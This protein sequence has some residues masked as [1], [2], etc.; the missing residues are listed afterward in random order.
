MDPRAGLDRCGKSRPPPGFD[1]WTVQ[2]V[3]SRHTNC[4]IPAHNNNNNNNNNNKFLNFSFLT[5]LP[6]T[7]KTDVEPLRFL[8][9]KIKNIFAGAVCASW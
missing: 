8:P 9:H 6:P 7:A 5:F 3:A 1:P 4:A 2:S